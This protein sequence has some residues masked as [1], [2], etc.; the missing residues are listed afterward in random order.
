MSYKKIRH[1]RDEMRKA[2]L[3]STICDLRMYS[4][5]VC[6]RHATRSQGPLP[7][8]PALPRAVSAPLPRRAQSPGALSHIHS[9]CC[10][11]L[12]RLGEEHSSCCIEPKLRFLQ[13]TCLEIEMSISGVVGCGC[14]LHVELEVSMAQL[15]RQ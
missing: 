13:S 4:M 8:C 11:A 9:P 7:S 6:A 5:H 3:S 14:G 1:T 10:S 12:V 2:Q 15:S